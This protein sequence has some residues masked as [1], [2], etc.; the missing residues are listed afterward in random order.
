[1][2]PRRLLT[3]LQHWPRRFSALLMLVLQ[4]GVGVSPLLDHDGRVP[5]RHMEQRGNR[6]PSAHN[7][8][9]CVVCAVRAV[10]TPAASSDAVPPIHHRRAVL[11]V[12]YVDV[13]PARDPPAGN[14]SRAPPIL[15]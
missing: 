9:T 14:S 12:A 7:E 6:H 5:A 3:R 1:M 11:A 8:R 15:S 4:V 2:T 13:A 10:Q